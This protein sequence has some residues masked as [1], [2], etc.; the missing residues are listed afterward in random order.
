M[1]EKSKGDRSS[2]LVIFPWDSR[3]VIERLQDRKLLI[4]PSFTL[5]TV[6]AHLPVRWTQTG[7]VRSVEFPWDRQGSKR[8]SFDVGVFEVPNML[9]AMGKEPGCIGFAHYMELPVADMLTYGP[10]PRDGKDDRH[11]HG[12]DGGNGGGSGGCNNNS[13]N[14]SNGSSSG[15][16]MFDAFRFSRE[17]YH[18]VCYP[19]VSLDRSKLI[20]EGPHA[21]KQLGIRNCTMKKL[22]ERLAHLASLRH[23]ILEDDKPI[24]LLDIESVSE[25]HHSLYSTLLFPPPLVLVS[26]APNVKTQINILARV[27][28]VKGAWVDFSLVEWRLRIGQLL[29]E[30]APHEDDNCLD[31][32]NNASRSGN[33]E[34]AENA[35]ERKWLLI[36]LV[37]SLELLLR[38]D[39]AVRVGLSG[40]SKQLVVTAHDTYALNSI[41]TDAS[42]WDIVVVRRLVENL[43]VLYVPYKKKEDELA[44]EKEQPPPPPTT[45]IKS[46]FKF[47]FH[48]SDDTPPIPPDEPAWSCVLLPKS[49]QRQL[50]GL[51]TFAEQLKWPNFEI[52]RD[53][54]TRKINAARSNPDIMKAMFSSA[55]RASP[56]PPGVPPL[57]RGDIFA[58]SRTCQLLRVHHPGQSAMRE[59]TYIGGWLSRSWLTGCVMP[60]ETIFHLLICTVL[61]NDPRAN[62]KL[63]PIVNL[64]GGFVYNHQS[65][66][67]RMCIV[68]RVLACMNN[69][70]E[71][72][73]WMYAPLTPETAE[74]EIHSD[75]WFEVE[76]IDVLR[77]EIKR[78]RICEPQAVLHDSS[79]LGWDGKLTASVFS[80]PL[81]ESKINPEVK[82]RGLQIDLERLIVD[83]L[84]GESQKPGRPLK[85]QASVKFR[86]KKMNGDE[87]AVTFPLSY[88]VC[89]ISSFPCLTPNGYIART[90]GESA[91]DTTD[92]REGGL[93]SG[94]STTVDDMDCGSGTGAAN[95]SCKRHRSRRLPGHLLHIASYPYEYISLETLPH[96]SSFPPREAML[97]VG[98]ILCHRTTTN[99][100]PADANTSTADNNDIPIIDDDAPCPK[101]KH[102][103][104]HRQSQSS[105]ARK[106]PKTTYIIDAR[107]DKNKEAFARAWCASV[108]ASAVVGRTCRTC[109]ACTIREARACDVDVV[110]R[111][112]GAEESF[113]CVSSAVYYL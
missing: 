21:W 79:P 28:G 104:H 101:H 106:G 99:S 25:L 102:S 108:G 45:S 71:C 13:N 10:S 94:P 100:G 59:P 29:W 18:A 55:V 109:L 30:Y 2:P 39:A 20:R 17:P 44:K 6:H 87:Q 23:Q 4:H 9:S 22:T 36:Q 90:K 11:V 53:N 98:D 76:A 16:G 3:A 73:G 5:G 103:H 41:R 78:A 1:L 82:N 57:D 95:Q 80:L 15:G 63:G 24:S 68:G 92:A 38:L 67:S 58:K 77:S 12:K 112:S 40:K 84:A 33:T 42:H 56:L 65:W 70:S 27:L 75:Q 54:L 48:S 60:G 19:A 26:H 93:A 69:A 50:G 8:A 110:I 61:E 86:L 47:K 113:E 31:H 74:G 14:S 81:D 7:I 46:R 43:D 83:P 96:I 66:W 34:D 51:L 91:L 85:T 97:E 64:Y 111:T 89:F 52:L 107:G 35:M 72:M 105:N 37:L 62:E 32:A 88:S 49:P